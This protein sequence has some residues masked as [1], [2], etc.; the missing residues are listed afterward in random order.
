M[1]AKDMFEQLGYK[2]IEDSCVIEYYNDE[3]KVRFWKESKHIELFGDEYLEGDLENHLY[4]VAR[5]EIYVAINQ[6]IKELGWDNVR[7]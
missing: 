4:Y 3:F 2:N 6:Q 7:N 5:F 1:K